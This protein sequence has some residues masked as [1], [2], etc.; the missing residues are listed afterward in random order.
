MPEAKRGPY[1][2]WQDSGPIG[3]IW[4]VPADRQSKVEVPDDVVGVDQENLRLGGFVFEII[5]AQGVL[6]DWLD[7]LPVHDG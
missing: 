6:Q 5:E 2:L 3:R 4:A 1:S 7:S